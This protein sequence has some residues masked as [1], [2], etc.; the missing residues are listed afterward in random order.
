MFSTIFFEPGEALAF[1]SG[2]TDA[3]AGAF[4]AAAADV[5]PAAAVRFALVAEPPIVRRF[6][7][8]SGDRS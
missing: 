3:A 7:R 2:A 1:V 8:V 4:L 6:C 5:L